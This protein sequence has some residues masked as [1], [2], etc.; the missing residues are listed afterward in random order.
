MSGPHART[1]D[2]VVAAV[3]SHARHGLDPDEAARRLAQD[4]PNELARSAAPSLLQRIM[5]EFRD[6]LVILLVVAVVISF[7]AWVLE[8]GDGLPYD[9][10]AITVIL[11]VNA[12]IGAAQARRADNAAAAL[13][14]LSA[15]HARVIRGGS[16]QRVPTSEV[17]VGDVVVLQAG[18]AVPADARVLTAHSLQTAEAAL[19][20]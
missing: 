17:V 2:D 11:C 12:G 14:R 10:I 16:V 13:E 7:V 15:T 8:G 20:A 9:S 6:P 1:A 4:G 18:D 3:A 19:T 5:N